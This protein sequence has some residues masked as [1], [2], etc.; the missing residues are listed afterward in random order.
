MIAGIN[1][2]SQKIET[3]IFDDLKYESRDRSYRASFKKNIF[4]DLQFSD[5]NGNNITLN[6]KYLDLIYDGILKDMDA[7][8][9]L[10]MQLIYKHR[11]DNRYKARYSVDIFDDVVIKENKTEKSI[12]GRINETLEFN[13]DN[14]NAT[15]QKDVFNKWVYKDSHGNEIKISKETWKSLI[16]RYRTKENILHHFVQD[17]L[18]L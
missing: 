10:F 15:L 9:E 6:K 4:D 18:I 5:S 1:S 8:S 16:N 13:S 17:L 14:V 3:D 12:K 7:K 11:H 2:Y